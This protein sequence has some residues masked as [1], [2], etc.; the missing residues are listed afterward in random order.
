[1]DEAPDDAVFPGLGMNFSDPADRT[2]FVQ[3]LQ[4]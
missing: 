2:R 3:L 4:F 1:M